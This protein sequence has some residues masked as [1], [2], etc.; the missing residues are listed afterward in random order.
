MTDKLDQ[1]NQK[2]PDP[3][4]QKRAAIFRAKTIHE[5]LKEVEALRVLVR[6]RECF[7]KGGVMAEISMYEYILRENP[8]YARFAD[9]DSLSVG[10]HQ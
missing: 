6:S 1:F 4:M 2:Y 7:P 9:L 3:G 10:A 8:A 5:Q